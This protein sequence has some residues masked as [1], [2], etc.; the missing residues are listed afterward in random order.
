MEV[1]GVLSPDVDDKGVELLDYVN[2]DIKI[3]GSS[4]NP[5]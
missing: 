3:F 5:L 2:N 4:H 1:Q